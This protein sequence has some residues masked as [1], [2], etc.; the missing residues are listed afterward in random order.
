MKQF[1]APSQTPS[2]YRLGRRAVAAKRR[3]PS[4]ARSS[5]SEQA[6]AGV[7]L[8]GNAAHSLRPAVAGQ[9]FDLSLRNVA[10]LAELLRGG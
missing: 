4:P 7:V 5:A 6:R 2:G 9:G 8:L 3:L 1:P 10:A